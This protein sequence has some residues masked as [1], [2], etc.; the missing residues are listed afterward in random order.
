MLEPPSEHP[1]LI[2]NTDN[3]NETRS[4]VSR[5]LR[6]AGFEVEEAASGEEALRLTAG[7]PDLVLLDADVDGGRDG[8]ELCRRLKADPATAA[9]PVVLL[10]ATWADLADCARAL[11]GGADGCL[12]KPIDLAY[13]LAHL[14]ALLR[15]RRAEEARHV[16]ESR[17]RAIIEKSFDAVVLLDADGTLLYASPSF[18]RV[19]GYTPEEWVG[20]DAFDLV[21]PEDRPEAARLFGAL[22]Q[23]P[24]RGEGT[25]HR[26]LHRDGSWRWLEARGTN[27]LGDPAVRAVVVNFHDITERKRL[28]ERLRQSQ[29]MEAIGQLAG[30]VAH[31]FNNLLTVV[32]ADADLLLDELRPDDPHRGLAAEVKKA[33]E[34]AAALT[35][36]LLAFGRKQVLAPRVLDLNEVVS[37]MGRLLLR[38]IGEDIE[39]VLYLQP[40]LAP[41]FAD[42]GQMEQVLLNLAVNAREAMPRGGRLVIRT[43]NVTLGE[44]YAR[45]HPEVVAGPYVLLELRDSGCGMSPEVK[46]RIFEPFFTT[47]GV[48]KGTGLGLAVVHGVV[49]QS[50]GH[51]EV[52]SEPGGGTS[53]KI[54]LPRAEPSGEPTKAVAEVPVSPRGSETVLVVED[55]EAVREVNRRILVRGGYAVLEASDGNEALR[56]AAQ[57][58]GPI[59]LLLTDVVMPGMGGRQL[60]EELSAL[61]PA[62]KVLYVSGYP[63]DA[64]VGHG[65]R[66]GEV[67]FL[68][69][70][71]S[72]SAL[73][74]K[75]REVLDGPRRR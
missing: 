72:P 9:I 50:G 61:H 65:I 5:L 4:A 35:R 45:T 40:G 75:V 14:K 8:L 24:G 16:T 58:R 17:F 64:I 26:A 47:K 10:S 37:Q 38:T 18:P 41:V 1:P 49:S 22:L 66:E 70:P 56:V 34:R 33:G 73:A 12:S 68:Q 44:G 29:R 13:L 31:E 39:L 54:Y 52:D 51:I 36:Q 48:G 53:F 7:K 42:Q 63:D 25:V 67:H 69:K 46:A 20:R 43:G 60:A 15:A 62:M 55:E 74:R 28:E 23:E 71:F 57:H 59:H 11:E 27:L 6:Q 19:L 21:H 32:N 30:G 3:D 2:L